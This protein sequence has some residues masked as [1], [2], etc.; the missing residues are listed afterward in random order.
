MP[1]LLLL[2]TYTNGAFRTQVGCKGQCHPFDAQNYA[3]LI[4]PLAQKGLYCL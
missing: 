2:G 4:K 1:P 3:S